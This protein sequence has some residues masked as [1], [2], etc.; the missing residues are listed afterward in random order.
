MFFRHLFW[1]RAG[2][3]GRVGY[4]EAGVGAAET[5]AALPWP[6]GLSARPTER[7]AFST[8]K[9]DVLTSRGLILLYRRPGQAPTPGLIER[10]APFWASLSAPFNIG[11]RRDPADA[12]R[13][14]CRRRTLAA[15]SCR[16]ITTVEFICPDRTGVPRITHLITFTTELS[17]AERIQGWAGF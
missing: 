15:S 14:C 5:T 8:L 11:S 3:D 2:G 13:A 10:G 17:F 12:A 9:T 16:D 6:R 4:R 7:R 1:R